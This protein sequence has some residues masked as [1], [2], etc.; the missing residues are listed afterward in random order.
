MAPA[1]LPRQ[2]PR[3]FARR[4]GAYLPRIADTLLASRLRSAG[5]VLVEGP[6]ACGK[7]FTAEQRARSQVFLDTDSRAR[8][9]LTIDP[10]LVIGGDPP[11]LIDE[12]QLEATTVWNYVRA[13]VDR[14]GVPGQFILTGSA[15]P[16][17]DVSRH[18]GAGRFARIRMRPMSLYESGESTGVMSLSSLLSGD[19]PDS[20][21][22]ELSV[23]DLIDLTV[24]GG[25]PLNLPM[26]I[27][28][29]AQANR[30]YL[31]SIAEVDITRVD[32]ASRDPR[33]ALILMRALARNVAL[34]HKI[35]RL[36]STIDEPDIQMARSTAYDYLA[37]FERLMIIEVQQAWSTHLRS[38]ATLRTAARTHFVDPSLAVAALGASPA[39]LVTDLNTFGFLFE[40]LA[41]RDL[42]IYA[43][44]LSGTVMHYRDSDQLEV[45]IIVS[46][47]DRW[48][49][50]E[51]KL[52]DAGIDEA[53]RKLLTFA[54]KIDSSKVGQPAVLGVITGTGFGYT[55]PDGVV[56]VPIG[57]L[58]P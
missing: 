7:T 14:R 45:D 13:Q 40:S 10:T 26:A 19:R 22:S 17:D 25:W 5:A 53:A 55:R 24:R 31:Q 36:V 18:T 12:W 39:S 9:A 54:G 15:V 6:K 35:A 4:A 58:G 23:T 41:V 47:D 29:A 42:R 30:D 38:R 1:E 27:A 20:T 46:T 21:A 28:D 37:A 11:Q 16:R 32:T 8:T 33:R 56:V 52:G 3:Q 51:V 44:A 2:F 34:D 49:A 50:F 43:D 57:A 48:A